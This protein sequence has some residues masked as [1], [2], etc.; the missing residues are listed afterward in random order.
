MISISRYCLRRPEWLISQHKIRRIGAGLMEDVAMV[1]T[2]NS[3]LFTRN[4]NLRIAHWP[5]IVPN[6]VVEML[7]YRALCLKAPAA[8][9]YAAL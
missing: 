7:C 6:A 2:V 5:E 8:A 1:I 4:P 3:T 9:G